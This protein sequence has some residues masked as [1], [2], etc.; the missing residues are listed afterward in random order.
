MGRRIRESD[1]GRPAGDY[2]CDNVG[3]GEW[4]GATIFISSRPDSLCS[5]RSIMPLS[6]LFRRFRPVPVLQR[7]SPFK[8]V[9][10][11]SCRWV[12]PRL[13]LIFQLT[14]DR[15]WA[16]PKK[17]CRFDAEEYRYLHAFLP[18]SKQSNKPINQPSA[19]DITVTDWLT[20][21]SLID[22][23]ICILDQLADQPSSKT[24]LY[25]AVTVE[26]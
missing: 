18:V 4:E 12:P 10:T 20:S 24:N 15:F 11:T 5:I 25:I 13:P 3:I 8:P 6:Q 1:F 26:I 21:I 14:L 17:E 22:W 23:L 19:S 9:K 16:T 2:V 7:R